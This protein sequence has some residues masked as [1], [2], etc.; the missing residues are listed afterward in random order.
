MMQILH[1][2]D[3]KFHNAI[4]SAITYKLSIISSV[5]FYALIHIPSIDAWK[6]AYAVLAV[7]SITIG[8]LLGIW[9]NRK[10][11]QD[12]FDK[13]EGLPKRK[14]APRT[15]LAR[16]VLITVL[17]AIALVTIFFLTSCSTSRKITTKQTI[18]CE[19]NELQSKELE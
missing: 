5:G 1:F 6:Y 8:I 9:K 13:L 11:F 15:R 2:I 16:I 18:K 17:S 4:E 10:E 3:H 12:M 14:L 7:I 19:S